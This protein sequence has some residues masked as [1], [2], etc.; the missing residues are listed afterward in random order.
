MNFQAHT[1][2]PIKPSNGNNATIELFDCPTQRKNDLARIH[3]LK[4]VNRMDDH[5]YRLAMF[6]VTG[7]KSAKFLTSAGRKAFISH[8]A[9][10]KG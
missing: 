4:R 9:Q 6:E 1:P 5:T 7:E 2:S 10:N 8:L 3:I